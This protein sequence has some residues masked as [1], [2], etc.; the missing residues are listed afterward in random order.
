M[1]YFAIFDTAILG[2]ILYAQVRN[3]IK[4]R[5]T[6]GYLRKRVI[7]ILS[8]VFLIIHCIRLSL[9]EATGIFLLGHIVAIAMIFEMFSLKPV[10]SW[11]KSKFK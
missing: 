7:M 1:K 11:I 4:Y 8:T 5:G 2:L 6:N 9:D 3:F 10:L